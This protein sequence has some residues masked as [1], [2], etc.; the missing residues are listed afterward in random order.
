MGRWADRQI[1]RWAGRQIG[2]WAGRQIGRWAGRGINCQIGANPL[3]MRKSS[4]IW[5]GSPVSA[6]SAGDDH[7]SPA[8]D[9]ARMN[10]SL[11]H[12]RVRLPARLPIC[13]PAD[14]P[15]CPSADLPTCLL[16]NHDRGVRRE[17]QRV[18]VRR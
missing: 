6:E 16:F 11:D 15:T 13:R 1:G 18:G 2:R 12:P 14:L 3:T 4:T 17:A 5:P 8:T 9:H 7:Y 10:S